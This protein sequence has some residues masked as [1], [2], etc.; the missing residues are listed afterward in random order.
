MGGG[1]LVAPP[2]PRV[3]RS[4]PPMPLPPPAPPGLGGGRLGPSEARTPNEPPPPLPP[5]GR[6]CPCPP[7]PAS[8]P[9]PAAPRG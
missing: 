2:I 6:L 5:P 3:G 1:A 9:P 7:M 8:L 4:P